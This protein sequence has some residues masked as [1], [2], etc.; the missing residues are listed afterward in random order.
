MKNQFLKIIKDIDVSMDFELLLAE[1]EDNSEYIGLKNGNT[2]KEYK[3]EAN[4]DFSYEKIEQFIKT[5]NAFKNKTTI[6][7]PKLKSKEKFVNN[8]DLRNITKDDLLKGKKHKNL[9]GPVLKLIEKGK[10]QESIKYQKALKE[11]KLIKNKIL[12]EREE[13]SINI[14]LE[15]DKYLESEGISENK[16][17]DNELQMD[18]ISMGLNKLEEIFNKGKMS[19]LKL[20]RA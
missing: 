19:F 13:F 12:K 8:L 1:E 6:S 18:K 16:N 10:D 9:T 11:I 20:K 17:K 3:I 7:D 14:R 4:E 2:Y 15:F 5:L